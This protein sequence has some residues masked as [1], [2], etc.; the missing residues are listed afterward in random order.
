MS[1]TYVCMCV[2]MYVCMYVCVYVS[3]YVC[4]SVCMRL[5]IC[6]YIYFFYAVGS[7]SGPHFGGFRANKWSTL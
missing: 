3:M 5:C 2:C 7:I 4:L 1:G 6:V